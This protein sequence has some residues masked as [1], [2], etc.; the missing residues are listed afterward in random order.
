M[1]TGFIKPELTDVNRGF[2][3]AAAEGVLSVQK[4][5][6]CRE[7]R[8]PP[9]LRCPNCLSAKWTWQPL[10]GR[11][12]VLSYVVIHQKYNAAWADRVPYNVAIIELEEG[13]RMISNMLPLSGG[14]VEVGMPVQVVFEDEDG[15]VIPR[16]APIVAEEN[17]GES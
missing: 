11:G 12:E 1:T 3:E 13:P 6:D 2:W 9:A 4:C 8:Y 5:E 10:S 14:D 7:L 17:Q 16:F 15:V